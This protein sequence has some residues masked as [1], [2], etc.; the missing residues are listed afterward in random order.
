MQWME[1]LLQGFLYDDVDSYL[2]DKTYRELLI[3]DLKSDGLIEKKSRHDE[4]CGSGKM[5][6]NSLGKCNSIRDIVFHEYEASGQDLRLLVL[7][8]Y[9]RKEYEKAIGNTEYDV[10]SLGVLPFLRCSV[11]TMKRKTNKS[12]LG[13]FVERL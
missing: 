5:L 8:D 1:R 10:N 11:V 13:C 12:V 9:I 6:T 7:T 3:A 2:C 4:K